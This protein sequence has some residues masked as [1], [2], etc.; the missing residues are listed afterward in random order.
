[1]IVHLTT[2]ILSKQIY[3][4]GTDGRDD[5]TSVTYRT[6]YLESLFTLDHSKSPLKLKT[7]VSDRNGT[8]NTLIDFL[9]LFLLETVLHVISCLLLYHQ[10]IQYLATLL[11]ALVTMFVFCH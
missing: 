11:E 10:G 6:N 8:R 4:I 1:M 9:D 7:A 5:I 3:F 2:K